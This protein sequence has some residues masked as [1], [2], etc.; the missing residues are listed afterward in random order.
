MDSYSLRAR[1]PGGRCEE[2]SKIE[3]QQGKRRV[4][5]TLVALERHRYVR[6]LRPPKY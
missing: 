1:E 3:A 2:I 5:A 6:Q 4:A